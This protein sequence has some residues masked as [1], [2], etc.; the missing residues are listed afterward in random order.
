MTGNLI[1]WLSHSQIAAGFSHHQ[2][3]SGVWGQSP[4]KGPCWWQSWWQEE[5]PG[6]IWALLQR[7]AALPKELQTITIWDQLSSSWFFS[8][9]LLLKSCWFQP[10]PQ[11]FSACG[12][13][14]P[15]SKGQRNITK[16]WFPIVAELVHQAAALALLHRHVSSAGQ[17]GDTGWARAVL[18]KKGR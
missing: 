8:A 13:R 4:A 15:F 9:R 1:I 6:I 7:G 16:M 2:S 17:P 3:V 18:Q 10:S 14:P 11:R 5:L 12:S